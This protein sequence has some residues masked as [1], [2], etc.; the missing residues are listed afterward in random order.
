[1]ISQPL[2]AQGNET[3]TKI[4]KVKGQD[5]ITNVLESLKFETCDRSILDRRL[6]YFF[7]LGTNVTMTFKN[8]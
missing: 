4:F 1:M 5:H 3:F 8:I 2:I 7:L 6:S